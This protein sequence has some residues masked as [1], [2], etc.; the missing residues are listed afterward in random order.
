VE[1]ATKLVS[2]LRGQALKEAA[3]TVDA[4]VKEAERRQSK[5]AKL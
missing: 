2:G 5:A 1:P 3:R 4:I